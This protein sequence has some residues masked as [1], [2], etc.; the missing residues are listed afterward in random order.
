MK[1]S[2]RIKKY[3]EKKKMTEDAAAEKLGVEVT[4]WK[5]WES[6]EETPDTEQTVRIAKILGTSANMLLYGEDADGARSM[7]PKDA[8]PSPTPMSDWRFLCGVLIMFSGGAGM[9]LFTVRYMTGAVNTVSELIKNGGVP[10]KL[11]FGLF[12]LGF[13]I[14]IAVCI[15]KAVSSRKKKKKK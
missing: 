11:L 3:R 4:L 13:F 9:L 12:L 8:A 7:F 1:T 6:G 10:L 5:K 15:S 14:C 2:D